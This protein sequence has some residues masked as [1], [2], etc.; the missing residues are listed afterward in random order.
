VTTQTLWILVAVVVAVA[1]VAVGVP[2][3][4]V[5]GTGAMAVPPL[6]FT[7]PPHTGVVPVFVT[8]M[9]VTTSVTPVGTVNASMAVAPAGTARVISTTFWTT[10][11]V[12]VPSVPVVPVGAGEML[13]VCAPSWLAATTPTIT[14]TIASTDFIGAP[15]V[16]RKLA[17]GLATTVPPTVAA[18]RSVA[19]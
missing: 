5:V 12:A 3:P 9:S 6:R 1:P 13:V 11:S 16:V 18:P 10:G 8:T 17:P 19:P 15:F 14:R 2:V 4:F 7:A